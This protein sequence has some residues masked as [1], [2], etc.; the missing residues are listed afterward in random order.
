MDL[1]SLL[2]I[3]GGLFVGWCIGANDAANCVGISVGAGILRYRKAA[4]I[5]GILAI[6]GATLQG[7]ASMATI[8]KGIIDPSA[9]TLVATISALFGAALTIT[10]FTLLS[11][12]IS[13]TQSI[14]GA[15]AGI[16]I[17]M[18]KPINW[19]VFFKIFGWGFGS[20]AVSLLISYFIYKFIS[21]LF[22]R[23]KFIVIE[24]GITI[25]VILSGAF[26]AYSLGANNMGNAMG[27]VVGNNLMGSAL[28]G[29]TGGIA[30]AF[31]ASIF[32]IKVMHTIG[33]KIT[34]LDAKM[35][36]SAQLGAAIIVFILALIGIPTS[37]TFAIVGGIVGV[38]LVK[39][40]ASVDKTTL[41]SITL[42]WVI[43]PI[44][45]AL[46]AIMLLKLFT[47]LF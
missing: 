1:L 39:G 10:I 27:L 16:G 35:A 20:F 8:G 19:S 29:L 17:I 38:G 24:K 3:L 34:A 30:L 43:T 14:I 11:L 4:I 18:T 6:A 37:I 32:G 47:F 42:G 5:V 21:R 31:G 23:G 26:L 22:S 46:F 33:T 13:T 2:L 28:A 41:R 12:P 7:S 40:V 15:I 36:F 9:I 45:G 44:I 25:L